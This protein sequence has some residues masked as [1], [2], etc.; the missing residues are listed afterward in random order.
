VKQRQSVEG[1]TTTYVW[2]ISCYFGINL[3]P[4]QGD[5]DPKRRRDRGESHREKDG[6][7]SRGREGREN[8]DNRDD[9]RKD[10]RDSKGRRD[11]TEG[12]ERPV[13]VDRVSDLT[14]MTCKHVDFKLQP[15]DKLPLP[16]LPPSA[17]RA[18]ANAENGGQPPR[19]PKS[20]L[21]QRERNYAPREAASTR[22]MSSGRDIPPYPTRDSPHHTTR[23]NGRDAPPPLEGPARGLGAPRRDPPV[24]R[25]YGAPRGAQ[26]D[27]GPSRDI[28]ARGN[29]YN[30]SD[31]PA[32]S[33]LMNRMND[34]DIRTRGQHPMNAR[35]GVGERHVQGHNITDGRDNDR[36]RGIEGK[37]LHLGHRR[38]D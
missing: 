25:E 17:P 5:R 36:K 29:G 9:R 10:E 8:R 13:A 4:K 15:L 27:Y 7:D 14:L 24:E 11:R 38:L 37:D 20:D 33:S 1:K 2:I 23:D 12:D 31:H 28:N 18:M 35:N 3:F 22:T 21:G 16:P 6:R 26:R 19:H 34:S 32:S 30:L